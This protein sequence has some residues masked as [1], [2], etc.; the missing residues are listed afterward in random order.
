M[1]ISL[2][3]TSVDVFVPY[4]GNLSVL[5]DHASAYAKAKNIDPAILLNLRLYPN[6]YNLTRQV[7]EANRHAVVACAL[8]AGREPHVFPEAEPDI[9]ELQSRIAAAIAFVQGLPRAEIDG[10][11]DKEVVFTFRSGATRKFTG[12]SLLLTFSVPQFFFHVTTAYDILR[13]AGVDLAKKD[14]LGPPR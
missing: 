8:L 1:T 6:M 4:L 7:G 3:E 9:A 11:A 12:R 13:H 5:L 2:C 14:F 10:A